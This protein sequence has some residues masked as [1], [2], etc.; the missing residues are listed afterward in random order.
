MYE[1]LASHMVL[2]LSENQMLSCFSHVGF[3]VTPWTVA[4]HTPLFM[5][6]PIWLITWFCYFQKIKNPF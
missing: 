5:G 3:F 4:C 2:L 1:Y 6:F